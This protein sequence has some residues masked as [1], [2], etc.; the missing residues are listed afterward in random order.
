MLLF[1]LRVLL[2]VPVLLRHSSCHV[3]V[4]GPTAEG[5]VSTLVD[6]GSEGKTVATAADATVEGSA[7]TSVED[8][9]RNGFDTAAFDLDNLRE[10][11]DALKKL[12]S[13]SPSPELRK[14]LRK[15][16]RQLE[17]LEK[18]KKA[19]ERRLELLD[20]C[21]DMSITRLGRTSPA[22]ADALKQLA[23][24]RLPRV[25]PDELDLHLMVAVCVNE[26]TDDDLD[27]FRRGELSVL[28]AALGLA[29]GQ[30]EASAYAVR[31]DAEFWNAL[32]DA[33]ADLSA[34]LAEQRTSES[35]FSA[36]GDMSLRKFGFFVAFAFAGP[37][38]RYLWQS[39]SAKARLVP[40]R[41]AKKR[42]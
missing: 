12:V 6:I 28:P 27:K 18:S 10:Q 38:I 2:L 1:E 8:S 24:D 32:R 26:L 14:R 31:L 34:K 37:C 41:E 40:L 25:G 4:D 29:A 22:S 11:L 9:D 20:P 19:A 16:E 39:A 35:K 33:S 17:N 36:F 7:P 5:Y 15:L 3:I 30:P 13:A 23:S 21:L 42:K